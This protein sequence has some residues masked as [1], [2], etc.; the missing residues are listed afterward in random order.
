M[1]HT[2]FFCHKHCYTSDLQSKTKK[3]QVVASL[4]VLKWIFL[5]CLNA[6]VGTGIP[7]MFHI[8]CNHFT[9]FRISWFE[10]EMCNE[11]CSI[12]P[13]IYFLLYLRAIWIWDWSGRQGTPQTNKEQFN[14]LGNQICSCFFHYIVLSI[15]III[16]K[17]MMR[18]NF[19]SYRDL[20]QF[21]NMFFL[22]CWVGKGY[23]IWE[24]DQS[25][26]IELPAV[27]WV[28]R[29]QKLES[30]SACDLVQRV[31]C[32]MCDWDVYWLGW[33]NL[34]GWKP[35]QRRMSE[36]RTYIR[37]LLSFLLIVSKRRSCMS[38]KY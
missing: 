38:S 29:L 28:Y 37:M 23:H 36:H 14:G 7:R 30:I 3:L 5:N 20:V 16:I 12:G 1:R 8:F 26:A 35:L 25:W 27:M 11:W 31:A 18:P 21:G 22:G 15:I 17:C 19:P 9:V 33:S 34:V 32:D 2:L 6:A 10:T 24:D 4:Y 13:C